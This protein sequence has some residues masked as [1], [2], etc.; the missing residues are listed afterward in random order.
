[1][2]SILN[3][4]TMPRLNETNYLIWHVCMC[5]LLICAEL[6]GITSGM[7]TTPDP[8]TASA[9]TVESFASCQLKAAAEITLYVEDSQIPHVQSDDPKV[10]WDEL[11]HVHRSRGL[12]TQLT[13]M[14]K[15][16]RMEKHQDQSISSW[17]DDI[18]AQVHLIKDIGITLPDLFVIVTL[19]SGLPAEFDSVVIALNSIE[20]KNLTLEVAISRL[21]NEEECH[22]SCKLMEDYKTSLI[23]GEP[24]VTDDSATY[25]ACVGKSN[26]TCFNCSKKGHYAKD[27]P[28]KESAHLAEEEPDGVW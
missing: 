17:I 18:K 6:W 8:K 26:V 19:T 4:T 25:A 11:A 16:S 13:A 9:A 2:A 5:T 21:L 15:F 22:L 24:D 1:M 27:C 3:T 10:I 28:K 14:W 20:S 12:S 23:K 7:E